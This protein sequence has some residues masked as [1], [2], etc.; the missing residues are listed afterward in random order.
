MGTRAR[1]RPAELVP[2]YRTVTD[3]HSVLTTRA[4]RDTLALMA[5]TPEIRRRTGRGFGPS[6]LQP[7]LAIM[8][9]DFV[10]STDTE[11]TTSRARVDICLTPHIPDLAAAEANRVLGYWYGVS[12]T[13]F[14]EFDDPLPPTITP[15][16]HPSRD[17]WMD[18]GTFVPQYT[19]FGTSTAEAAITP[20]VQVPMGGH[21]DTKSSRLHPPGMFS[22]TWL[23]ISVRRLDS[24]PDGL[25]PDCW[26]AYVSSVVQLTGRP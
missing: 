20:G 23:V 24:D 21:I 14:A 25:I 15:F 4:S 12:T 13:V 18:I 2:V 3:C 5:R 17:E 10:R 11:G 6:E 22:M 7:N 16:D 9:M 26:M 19:A 1:T 8:L